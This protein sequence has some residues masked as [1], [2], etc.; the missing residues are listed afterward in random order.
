MKKKLLKEYFGYDE[1]REGQEDIIDNLL[2]GK[3]VL[4]IMPTGMGKSL[5]Y[6][7]PSLILN[8]I[9]LV[10]SPLISLMKD[11][12]MKLN[13]EQIPSAY[14]NSSLAFENVSKYKYKIVYVS[15]ERLQTEEFLVFAK[16]VKISLIAVDEAHCISQWGNHCSNCL[17]DFKESDVT[18][19]AKSIIGCVKESGERF[20]VSTIH[21]IL[22]GEDVPRLQR[23]HLPENSY[24]GRLKGIDY[25]LVKDTVN[26]LLVRD[27]L[28]RPSGAY[29]TIRTTIKSAE[30]LTGNAKITIKR[31][32]YQK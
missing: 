10:V 26:E 7:L 2:D 18:D 27:Y 22:S 5:C 13:M 11:Q 30:L 31:P 17:T 14:I 32:M 8:G 4:A 1:F 15:P 3:D 20:G 29:I 12:V 6:Q 23:Y 19:M 21:S 24:F 16:S 9:T 28:I 25:S